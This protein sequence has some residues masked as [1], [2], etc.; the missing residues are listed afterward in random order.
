M[1]P[2]VKER[3]QRFASRDAWRGR[4]LADSALH[5]GQKRW[6]MYRPIG[7]TFEKDLSPALMH[8]YPS[9]IRIAA[10]CLDLLCFQCGSHQRDNPLDP[11]ASQPGNGKRRLSPS[12]YPCPKRSPASSTESSPGSRRPACN[13]RQAA[14]PLASGACDA[15]HRRHLPRSG[16]TLF[17]EGFDIDGEVIVTRVARNIQVVV[18]DTTQRLHLSATCRVREGQRQLRQSLTPPRPWPS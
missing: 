5:L 9:N 3:G 4:P 14:R 1:V 6:W 7:R 13:D 11:S 17:I 16:R 10:I 18:G 15:R 8:D 2:T 12:S